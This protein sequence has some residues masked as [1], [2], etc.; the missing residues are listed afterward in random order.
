MFVV[1]VPATSANLGPGFD[2]M[3]LALSLYNIFQVELGDCLQ[4]RLRGKYTR[5]IAPN[6]RNIFWKSAC[7]LWE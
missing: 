1:K 6:K 4:F 3:G 7:A 2:C 5:F